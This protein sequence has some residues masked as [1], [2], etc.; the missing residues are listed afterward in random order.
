VEPLTIALAG[1]LA[2]LALR[3]FGG[4]KA[5]GG[6]GAPESTSSAF[7]PF[8]PDQQAAAWYAATGLQWSPIADQRDSAGRVARAYRGQSG[9]DPGTNRTINDASFR[10]LM[11]QGY[12]VAVSE[13]VLY[14]GGIATMLTFADGFGAGGVPPELGTLRL[15]FAPPPGSLGQPGP[16]PVPNFGGSVEPSLGA[17]AAV[18]EPAKS[19][20]IALYQS[21]EASL[22]E[23]DNVAKELDKAGYPEAAAAMRKRRDDL[24]LARSLEAK[25]RGGW[26]YVVRTGDLPINVAQWYGGNK[27]G[28]LKELSSVNRASGVSTSTSEWPGWIGGREVLLPAG[29]P[30]PGLKA[31]PPLASGGSKPAGG[32]AKP[33]AGGSSTV[34]FSSTMTPWGLY[35]TDQP[36]PPGTTAQQ[37]PGGGQEAFPVPPSST[38]PNGFVWGPPWVGKWKPPTPGGIDPYGSPPVSGPFGPLLGEFG[39]DQEG[40]V[41]PALFAQS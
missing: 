22:L 34:P 11:S 21:D 39:P 10:Q 14:G 27:A 19:K 40:G 24:L 9:G 26:L 6:G 32:G 12:R 1:G 15:L 36:L 28:V 2:Y 23:L 29:W 13:S 35:T 33:P 18:P 31:L 25:E 4:K 30:D 8:P 3:A 16:G 37:V 5:G 17:F 7:P 41:T 20:A 38:A